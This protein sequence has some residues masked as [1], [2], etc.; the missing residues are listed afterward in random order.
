MSPGVVVEEMIRS[1]SEQS[2]T[3]RDARYS[4]SLIGANLQVLTRRRM[5]VPVIYR[6]I[7]VVPRKIIP[8]VLKWMKGIFISNRQPVASRYQDS[9]LGRTTIAGTTCL[10][11]G[12]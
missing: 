7:E 8:F 4:G 10:S 3:A 2:R 12:D 11:Q 5:S 1:L 6:Q 9:C